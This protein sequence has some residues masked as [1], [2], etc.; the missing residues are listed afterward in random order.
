MP[1]PTPPI[2]LHEKQETTRLLLACGADI[3][4]INAVRKH[5]SAMKGGQ[6]ARLAA[7]AHVIGLILSDVVGDDMS[8][9][10]SG[11]TAPDEST[12]ETLSPF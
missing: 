5:L 7:P 10:A 8:A 4:E 2:T 1:F 3:Q 12:Y 9:I 6:L 11:P